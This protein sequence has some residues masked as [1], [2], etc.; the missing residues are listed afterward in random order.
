LCTCGISA[1]NIPR[2]FRCE[3]TQSVRGTITGIAEV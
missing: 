3:L 2:H 1:W